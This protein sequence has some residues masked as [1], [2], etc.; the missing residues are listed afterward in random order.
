MATRSIESNIPG[1]VVCFSYVRNHHYLRLTGDDG[2]ETTLIEEGLV[3]YH[4]TDCDLIFFLTTRQANCCPR[5]TSQALEA[6]WQR[7]QVA[8]VPE[9]ETDFQFVRGPADEE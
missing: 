1:D 4:C 7:P 2:R 9:S 8:L 6:Q 3:K 5:C